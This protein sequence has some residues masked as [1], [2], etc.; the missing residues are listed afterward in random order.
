MTRP[1]RIVHAA[2]ALVVAFYALAPLLWLLLASFRTNEAVMALPIE[3][4]PRD[5]TIAAY[6]DL[7]AEGSHA[8]QLLDW[9]IL[10]ANSTLIAVASTAVVVALATIAGYAFA[11]LRFPAQ[12]LILAGLLI[13][14]MFQGASLLLPTFR[15]V[16]AMGLYDSPWA[17]V[18]IYSAFGVPFATWI[19]ASGMREIP[20]ELDEAAMMDG[21]SRLGVLRRV[22]LPLAQPAIVTAAMWHFVGAWSEFAFASVLLESLESKTVPLG[23]VAFVDYFTLEFNRVGAAAAL[24]ALPVLALFLAGQRFFARGLLAGAVKG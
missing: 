21:C 24:M 4:W 18:V 9:P 10:F 8:R 7:F 15:L 13:S 12:D 2:L 5:P 1:W 23:L 11:R 19:V 22:V 14:R 3:Y 16:S 17:L 20:V 6:L